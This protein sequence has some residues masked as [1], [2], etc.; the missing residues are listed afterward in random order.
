MGEALSWCR[1]GGCWD[2][3]GACLMG[4]CDG[5]HPSDRERSFRCPQR[6]GLTATVAYVTTSVNG[7]WGRRGESSG[8]GEERGRDN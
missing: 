5:W 3:A 2:G 4:Y 6:A 1:Y 7:W 8:V